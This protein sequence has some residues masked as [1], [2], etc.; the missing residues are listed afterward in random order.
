MLVS[1]SAQSAFLQS[2]AGQGQDGDGLLDLVVVN[3]ATEEPHAAYTT[4]IAKDVNRALLAT[5]SEVEA[6]R[7]GTRIS[8]DTHSLTAARTGQYRVTHADA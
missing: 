4:P 7:A 3:P 8:V 1:M 6:W 2:I 5:V